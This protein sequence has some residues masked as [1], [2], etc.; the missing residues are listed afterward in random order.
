[1]ENILKQFSVTLS[2]FMPERIGV[3]SYWKFTVIIFSCI[4]VFTIVSGWVL[5]IF[6]STDSSVQVPVKIN[7]SDVTMSDIDKVKEITEYKENRLSEII[8][9][10]IE[11]KD[12]K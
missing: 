4:F 10:D 7:R 8:K 9:S 2:R 12:L 1:M 5:Y 6:V 11:I 3:K